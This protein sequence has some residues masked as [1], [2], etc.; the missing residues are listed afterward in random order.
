MIVLVGESGGA[1][2]THIAAGADILL[3]IFLYFVL[4]LFRCVHACKDS[5]PHCS[6]F[7]LFQTTFFFVLFCISVETL[8]V[9]AVIFFDFSFVCWYLFFKNIYYIVLIIVYIMVV[10]N[11]IWYIKYKYGMFIIYYICWC[12][13]CWW[14]CYKGEM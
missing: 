8:V 7:C 13:C 9:A 12:L 3:R 2:H 6:F 5:S 4:F 1:T 10:V 11:I 14:C